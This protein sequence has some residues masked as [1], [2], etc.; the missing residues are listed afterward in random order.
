MWFVGAEVRDP[1]ITKLDGV[2]S[3]RLPEGRQLP[4]IV[5]VDSNVLDSSHDDLVAT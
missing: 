3:S 1:L 2:A 5:A 4:W